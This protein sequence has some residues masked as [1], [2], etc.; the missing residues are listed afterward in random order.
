MKKHIRR[1]VRNSE[2]GVS[3]FRL[4]LK[5]SGLRKAFLSISFA[6]VLL[7][8]GFFFWISLDV[9]S[10][11]LLFIGLGVFLIGLT[12]RI[13]FYE[14]IEFNRSQQTFKYSII[15][16]GSKI[17]NETEKPLSESLEKI[18]IDWNAEELRKTITARIVTPQNVFWITC[19]KDQH[20]RLLDWYSKNFIKPQTTE[21]EF[22]LESS[23]FQP[24]LESTGR[25]RTFN[26]IAAWVRFE[27]NMVIKTW[28]HLG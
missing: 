25:W 13:Q 26:E 28:K 8:Y 7:F 16:L 24:G 19:S 18:R 9:I 27:V 1:K 15:R 14:W 12:L 3:S 22:E 23:G 4:D 6:F 21:Q 2:F 11:G 10:S 17:I 5:T 20:N